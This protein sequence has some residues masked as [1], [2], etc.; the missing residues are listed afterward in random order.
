M[1]RRIGMDLF[2][3][4]LTCAA[5]CVTHQAYLRQ[6]APC[7][8]L[9]PASVWTYEVDGIK[10]LVV[11]HPDGNIVIIKI[12]DVRPCDCTLPECKP[13]CAELKS[14]AASATSRICPGPAPAPAK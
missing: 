10:Y 8:S 13:M 4:A 6:G 7:Q 2:S 9:P 3:V 12:D 5:G 1:K 14:S 11:R